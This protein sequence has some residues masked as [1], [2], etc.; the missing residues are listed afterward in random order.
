M[1]LGRIGLAGALLGMSLFASGPA[2][3]I[4]TGH[5]RFP[6]D[7]TPTTTAIAVKVRS[8][9]NGICGYKI[10]NV[11]GTLSVS[12]STPAELDIYMF[13]DDGLGGTPQ[14]HQFKAGDCGTTSITS[15]P[16]STYA[17]VVLAV[18]ACGSTPA[19]QLSANFDVSF[20][21]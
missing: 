6:C 9:L 15:L 16:P 11:T 3:A 5:I 10:D 19:Q 2:R 4:S 7:D 1:R 20:N 12:P 21:Y 18:N 8:D 13:A 14:A 17:I